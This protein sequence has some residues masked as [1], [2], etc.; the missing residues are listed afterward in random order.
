MGLSY[1][2]ENYLKAILKLSGSPDGTV[3]TNAIAAQLDTSA[4]SVTDM[5]KKL[6][7]KEL[8]TYQR[9]KGASLTD[10]GQRIATTL[11]RKHRLWEVFLVQSLGM[12]W[13]EVHEIAEEL[14]HIQSDRLIDRLDHFLGHPKFDPHG[15]PIPN[16]QGKYTLRAQI[17]LSE[18]KPGQEGIVIGVREDETSFLKHLNEKGLT[19]GKS[20]KVITN[21]DYDNTLSLQVEGHELNLSGKVARNIMIKTT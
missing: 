18:L 9:Y 2:E 8:I 21:D 13:D 6:S 4:A 10:D 16:A 1:A 19:L 12:T 15:D 3:S 14:E 7:D 17:P 11:V 5:L 20:I